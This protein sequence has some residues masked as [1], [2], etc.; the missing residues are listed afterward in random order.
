MVEGSRRVDR[1]IAS[2]RYSKEPLISGDGEEGF[3]GFGACDQHNVSQGCTQYRPALN[4]PGR[5]EMDHA[6]ITRE[7]DHTISTLGQIKGDDVRSQ[8]P[9]PDLPPLGLPP[10][11]LPPPLDPRALIFSLNFALSS[12]DMF[13]YSCMRF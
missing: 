10:L 13:L 12:S 11:G 1:P 4:L 7:S 5:T 6:S 9:P 3:D 2:Y 8:I